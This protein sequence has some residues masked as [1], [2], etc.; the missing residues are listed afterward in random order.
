[1]GELS[2]S[3][4]QH[5][6]AMQESQQHQKEASRLQQKLQSSREGLKSLQLKVG[7]GKVGRPEGQLPSQP[8]QLL[9]PA[10]ELSW[11]QP[12]AFWYVLPAGAREPVGAG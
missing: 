5:Q 10:G 3:K 8:S 1:M 2:Q 11:W 9:L 4:Q 7:K 12:E 6:A